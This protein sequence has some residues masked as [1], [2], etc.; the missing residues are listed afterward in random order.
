MYVGS[1]EGLNRDGWRV[2]GS[3]IGT[4]EGNCADGNTDA[5]DVGTKE[6]DLDGNVE[7]CTLGFFVGD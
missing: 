3:L 7:G 2:G 1:A 4:T 5:L 6:G